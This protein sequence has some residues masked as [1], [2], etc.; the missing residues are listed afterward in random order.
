M[1]PLRNRIIDPQEFNQIVMLSQQWFVCGLGKFVVY[2]DSNLNFS[3]LSGVPIERGL[4]PSL[5]GYASLSAVFRLS[6]DELLSQ[7]PWII[8]G[9]PRRR[10]RIKGVRSPARDFRKPDCR[11]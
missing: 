11:L 8:V 2:R 9:P 3:R 4:I 5:W 6:M 1:E 7:F 10:M